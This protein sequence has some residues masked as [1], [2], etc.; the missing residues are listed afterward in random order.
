MQVKLKFGILYLYTQE[1]YSLFFILLFR[2]FLCNK[3]K[4]FVASLTKKIIKNV[5]K[6]A[7]KEY[8]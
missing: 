6:T 2:D 1:I 5:T 8:L 4:R 3:M 7:D